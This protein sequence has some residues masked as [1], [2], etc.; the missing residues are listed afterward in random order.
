[1]DFKFNK[2]KTGKDKAR[3]THDLYGNHS[4]K[5]VRI[6]EQCNENHQK[7]IQQERVDKNNNEKETGTG[8]GK[9]KGKGKK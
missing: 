9:W 7:N 3:K 5:H 4:A 6:Q 8:K 1:M 2:R